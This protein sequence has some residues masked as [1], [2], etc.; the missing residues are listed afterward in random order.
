MDI[1][2]NPVVIGL[3][4][5]VL[6][7]LYLTW[8]QKKQEKLNKHKKGKNNKKS[9]YVSL[10]IPGVVGVIVFFIAYGYFEYNKKSVQPSLPTN[11]VSLPLP[12]VPGY[13]L[14]KDVSSDQIRSF[15]LA[16]KGVKIP[17]KLPDVFIET[18]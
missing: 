13:K 11:N 15:S 17:S 8:R 5:A 16:N 2:K 10:I 4:V 7:Y 18:F 6:T 14:V 3:V 12:V 1:I 9:K